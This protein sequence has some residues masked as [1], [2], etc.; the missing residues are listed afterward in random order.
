MLDLGTAVRRRRKDQRLTLVD[1]ATMMEATADEMSKVATS[2][3]RYFK[4]RSPEIGA[5]MAAAWE[6]G[7]RESLGLTCGLV[8]ARK[9]V[10]IEPERR[11]GS[12]ELLLDLL[13]RRGGEIVATQAEIAREVGAPASTVSRA[14]ARLLKRGEIARQARRL[15]LLSPGRGLSSG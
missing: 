5:R 2:L 6:S 7:I 10:P 3:R 14:I 13:R 11:A 8:Q 12:D 15:T 4:H 1:L 9:P